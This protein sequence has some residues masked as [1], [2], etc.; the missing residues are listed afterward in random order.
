MMSI[1]RNDGLG[2]WVCL[3]TQPVREQLAKSSLLEGGFETFLP[4]YKKTIVRGRKRSDVLRPLFPRY[5]FA[6]PM[7]ASCNLASA[8][9]LTGVS[10]FA[11]P[12]LAQSYVGDEVINLLRRRQDADGIVHM[13]FGHLKPGQKVQVTGGPFAGFEA[14]FAETNDQKRSWIFIELL[15]KANRVLVSNQQIEVAA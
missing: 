12:S 1:E 2:N 10:S 13:D 9:R 4:V 15:G 5:V 14:A 3:F 6:R 8:Y 11:G 7:S